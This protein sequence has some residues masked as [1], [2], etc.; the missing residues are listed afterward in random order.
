MTA[1]AIQQPFSNLQLELLK[2]YSS[3]VSESDLKQIKLF[4]ARY[5][6]EKAMDEADRIWQEKNYTAEK[7]LKT[8]RRTSYN[9]K[10]SK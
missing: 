1:T 7:I 10:K 9:S 4:L 2:L 5:F 8:H 6:A 3:D